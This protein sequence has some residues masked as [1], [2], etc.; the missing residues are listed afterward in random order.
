MAILHYL[1]VFLRKM[2]GTWHQKNFPTKF[3]I[4]RDVLSVID[5]P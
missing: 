2:L 3:H 4:I 1:R 5:R